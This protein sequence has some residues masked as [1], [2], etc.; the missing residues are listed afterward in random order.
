MWIGIGV[1]VAIFIVT[2]IG[3]LLIMR[4]PGTEF[5]KVGKTTYEVML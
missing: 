5:A 4:K 2:L 1:G 3:V